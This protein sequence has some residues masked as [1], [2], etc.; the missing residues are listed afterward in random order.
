MHYY[1]DGY[2]FIFTCDLDSDDIQNSRKILLEWLCDLV[3]DHKLTITVVF[4]AGRQD[5]HAKRS[6]YH[7]IEV[8]YSGKGETAD[9][10]LLNI[11][12]SKKDKSRSVLVTSDKQLQRVAGH[13]HIK[14]ESVHTFLK[15][16]EKKERS[17]H[18]HEK[19]PTLTNLR[20]VE[21]WERIFT[22]RLKER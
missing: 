12:E 4:D 13:L 19:K 2:N 14:T 8:I 3:S 21:E 17:K 15:K 22:K 7:S 6:H 10:L 5:E 20:E 1:L 11:F 16:L 9:A 18:A